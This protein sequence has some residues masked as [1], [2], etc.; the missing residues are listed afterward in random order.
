[1]KG[2]VKMGKPT[3]ELATELTIAYINSSKCDATV[4]DVQ[5]FLKTTHDTLNEMLNPK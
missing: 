3:Y 4:D 5:T 2:G 1:V